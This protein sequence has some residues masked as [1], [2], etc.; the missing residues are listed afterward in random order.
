MDNIVLILNYRI[1][2]GA[3]FLF[4]FFTYTICMISCS[5]VVGVYY[6]LNPHV[7]VPQG[8]QLYYIL[9]FYYFIF[10][11]INNIIIYTSRCFNEN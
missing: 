4:K 10:S 7:H 3:I 2:Y 6:K 1:Y 11:T 8:Q 5:I 9:L